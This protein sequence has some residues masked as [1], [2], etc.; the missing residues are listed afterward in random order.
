M[1]VAFEDKLVYNE[2]LVSKVKGFFKKEDLSDPCFKLAYIPST[3]Q[4]NYGV[5]LRTGKPAPYPLVSV[6][7]VFIF[8]GTVCHSA[9]EKFIIGTCSP[10]LTC[11]ACFNMLADILLH[12]GVK[13]VTRCSISFLSR[14]FFISCLFLWVQTKK[15]SHRSKHEP[16]CIC[17]NLFQDSLVL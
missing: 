17:S 15:T 6:K 5:D 2:E 11:V 12:R 9:T 3:S 10:S 1:A 4:L 16:I 14:K 13:L 8:P 7:N